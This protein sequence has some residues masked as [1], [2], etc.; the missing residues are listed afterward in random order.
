MNYELYD[1]LTIEDK[2][3]T[4]ASIIVDEKWEYFLLLGINNE[5]EINPEEIKIQKRP[6][7]NNINPKKLYPVEDEQELKKVSRLLEN[8][9]LDNVKEVE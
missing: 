1:I 3:Y 7:E 8:A 9:M 2:E 4:I 5:E 6:L